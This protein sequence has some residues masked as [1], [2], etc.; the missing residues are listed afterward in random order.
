[1][2]ELLKSD[3]MEA[4][5]RLETLGEQLKNSAV[6]AEFEQLEG[7]VEGLDTDN[8]MSSLKEIAIEMG[9]SL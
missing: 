8:A 6:W 2:G 7:Y 3:L 4:M 5:K 1:M 9:I